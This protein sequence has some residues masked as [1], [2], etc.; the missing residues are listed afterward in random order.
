MREMDA[1]NWY[2][3]EY[4][5]DLR[6]V[7]FCLAD[8]GR[9]GC[10][11]DAL[12]GEEG[13]CEI[14]CPQTVNH[15]KWLLEGGLPKEHAPQVYF[16]LWVTRRSWWRFISYHS[17]FPKLVVTVRPDEKIEKQIEGA[18]AGFYLAFDQAWEK[19]T[20]LKNAA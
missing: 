20:Q 10:S 16:S 8:D 14:K 1:F 9:S 7:G 4:D 17:R 2:S 12:I 11:P 19:L 15:L 5:E 3:L 13:G 18:L 6:R